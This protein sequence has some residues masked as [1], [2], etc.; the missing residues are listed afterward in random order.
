[1]TFSSKYSFGDEVIYKR[2]RWM[3]VGIKLSAYASIESQLSEGQIERYDL[4]NAIS[5][6]WRMNI[7]LED[8]KDASKPKATYI[9]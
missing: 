6:C 2:R 4:S 7:P 5:T 8:L 1:M 9:E 3:V